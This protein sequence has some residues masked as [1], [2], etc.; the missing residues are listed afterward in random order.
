[1]Q[2]RNLVLP[3]LFSLFASPLFSLAQSSSGSVGPFL[4]LGAFHQRSTK[5]KRKK[6]VE[7]VNGPVLKRNSIEGGG[8]F[9]ENEKQQ[10][11]HEMY[12]RREP[13]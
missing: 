10:Q 9:D 3:H 11:P 5:L 8:F 13:R 4:S 12:E 7:D 1:V 6:R 2:C